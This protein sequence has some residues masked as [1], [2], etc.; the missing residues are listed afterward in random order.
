MRWCIGVTTLSELK[1]GLRESGE[2]LDDGEGNRTLSVPVESA[3]PLPPFNLF[4]VQF[5]CL[6]I[7]SY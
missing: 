1:V 5:F 4:I 7:F 2:R 6:L 3:N